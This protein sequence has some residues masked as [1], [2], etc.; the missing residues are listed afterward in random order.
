MGL[1]SVFLFHFLQVA[2]VLPK[3]K[4]NDPPFGN[5]SVDGT[6]RARVR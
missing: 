6:W 4:I 3:R 2:T 1:V 5:L